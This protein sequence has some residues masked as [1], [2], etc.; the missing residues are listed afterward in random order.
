MAELPIGIDLG[1]TFSV[2]AHLD[3]QGRPWTVANAEGDLT[4]PSVVFFDQTQT[5]VGK[6]ALKAAEFEPDRVAR[7]VKRSMGRPDLERPVCGRKLPPEVVQALILKKV[8]QD[9]ERK[10]GP[11]TQAVI[12]VPAYFNEPRRKATADAGRLAGLEVLDIINEPTAA[13]IAFGVQQGFLEPAGSSP[14]R[15][16]ILVYDLGGGTFDVTLMEIEGQDYRALATSGDVYLGGIEWDLCIVDLAAERFQAEFGTDPR[17]DAHAAQ[18]LLSEAVDAKHALSARDETTL[19]FTH[20][21]HRLRMSITREQF[22]SLTNTLLERTR[23]R[24]AKVFRDS[25]RTWKDV[26]RLLLAGGSTR[27]PMVQQML[28]RE[29]GLPADHSLAPDEAVA[30]GAAVYAGLL[31]QSD[32]IPCRGMSVANINSHDLGVLGIE[33]ETGRR[34]RRVLIPRNTTLPAARTAT[35]VTRKPGQANVRVT[36]VEGGDATGH[37]A[38]YIGKCVVRD[39][40]VELPAKSQ[41]EVAFH[42][43]PGGQLQVDAAVPSTGCQATTTIHRAA[44]M[45]DD[46]LTDWRQR[47]EA[48][49]LFDTVPAAERAERAEIPTRAASADPADTADTPRID[50]A[51]VAKDSKDPD[52]A[53]MVPVLADGLESGEPLDLGD[54]PDLIG[55]QPPI[56]LDEL[57]KLKPDGDA[58]PEAVSGGPDDALRNF[59][60]GIGKT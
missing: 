19:H 51:S 25:K 59:L 40:P 24:V 2:V 50:T 54:L 38:T 45:S 17:Q 46:E 52:A 48:G 15:E 14:R 57:A 16:T 18:A 56:D 5:V 13:A 37:N 58:Q 12:T 41:V 23:L 31:S 4:T 53:A 11:V 6:E 1:T 47:I 35:F 33:P 10:L 20:D 9:A 49:T 44:G 27:M 7:F 55:G 29:S 39:L 28:E 3:N 26:T 34:R 36:V 32:G 8:K 43:T 30:H 21:G 60:Q 42:Y 22:E